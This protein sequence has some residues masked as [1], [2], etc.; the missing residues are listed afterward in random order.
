MKYK[1]ILLLFIILNGCASNAVK[2]APTPEAS[3]RLIEDATL[4]LQSQDYARAMELATQSVAFDPNNARAY[5]VLGLIHQRQRNLEQA[6]ANFSKALELDPNDVAI[7][8]NYGSY[9]CA[10]RRYSEAQE[11]FL[12]AANNP[13]NP[14]P[15]IALANAGLCA[16]RAN[17][18]ARAIKFQ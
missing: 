18:K 16:L 2:R 10:N 11:S 13:S 4:A 5:S 6:Q 17:D 1:L 12:A 3:T 14:D 9:L 15:D 8:N 7:R